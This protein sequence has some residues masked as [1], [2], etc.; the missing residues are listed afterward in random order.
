MPEEPYMPQMG[1]RVQ[2]RK[3]HPC[4]GD[5]WQVVRVGSDIGLTCERC[6]RKVLLERHVLRKRVKKLLPP[7]RTSEEQ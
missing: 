4:G 7:N 3:Q 6:G 2:L 5:V 1:D